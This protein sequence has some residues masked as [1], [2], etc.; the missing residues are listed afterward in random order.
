MKRSEFIIEIADILKRTDLDERIKIWLNQALINISRSYNFKEMET[1]VP[2][3]TSE[4]FPSDIKMPKTL[5]II[6]GTQSLKLD[7]ILVDD[8]DDNYPN[9]SAD[10]KG[11]PDSYLWWG[12]VDYELIPNVDK[13]YNM[14]LRYY[15]YAPPFSSDVDTSIFKNK[16]DLIICAGVIEGYLAL[17]SKEDLEQATIWANKYTGILQSIITVEKELLNE[18]WQP[19]I[20][21]DRHTLP[22]E[23]WKYPFI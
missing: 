8:T 13:L 5:R 22:Y 17:A 21:Y 11:K 14:K 18:S 3:T 23:Y 15:K 19:T 2:L 6:D 12:L 16:D 1:I 9:P 4:T 10:T 20:N 7:M